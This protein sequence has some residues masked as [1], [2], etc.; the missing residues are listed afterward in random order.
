MQI[1]EAFLKPQCALA[2]DIAT[3]ARSAQDRRPGAAP[4]PFY[5]FSSLPGQLLISDGIIFLKGFNGDNET[6]RSFAV[7]YQPIICKSM[8]NFT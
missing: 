6:G 8:K 7:I 4:Y 1:K 2:T 3:G 5:F